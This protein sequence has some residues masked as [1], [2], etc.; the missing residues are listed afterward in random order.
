MYRK[1]KSTALFE[2]QIFCNIINV[3]FN[4]YQ[5]NG[6]LMNKSVNV[7]LTNNSFVCVC[8]CVMLS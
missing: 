3:F 1:F 7:L 6:S 5:F 4:L 2:I 8:V